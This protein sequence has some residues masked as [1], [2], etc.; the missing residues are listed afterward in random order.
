MPENRN[1]FSVAS[2][3]NFIYVIERYMGE[4]DLKEKGEFLFANEGWI[5][6][7][8]NKDY[9][10]HLTDPVS[11]GDLLVILDHSESF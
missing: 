8:T 10:N 5:N 2:I 7:P 9:T 6:L 11:L 4:E 3:N 1:R